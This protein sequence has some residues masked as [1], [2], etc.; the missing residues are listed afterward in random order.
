MRVSVAFF[1]LTPRSCCVLFCRKVDEAERRI[2]HGIITND[3]V[4]ADTCYVEAVRITPEII[5]CVSSFHYSVRAHTYT[6]IVRSST[7]FTRNSDM[8]AMWSALLH[9]MRPTLSYRTCPGMELFT[10]CSR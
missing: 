8:E 9:R 4:I 3:S 7:Q 10:L 1:R 5:K 2:L 6:S